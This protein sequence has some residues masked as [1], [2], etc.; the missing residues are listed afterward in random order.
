MVASTPAPEEQ[1]NLVG[2]AECGMCTK[3]ATP[4]TIPALQVRC[5]SHHAHSPVPSLMHFISPTPMVY[6][7][8][9]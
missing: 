2:H 7:K 1:L 6:S 5:S 3:A 4:P 9:G 8:L